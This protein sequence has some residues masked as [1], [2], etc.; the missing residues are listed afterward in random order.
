MLNSIKSTKLKDIFSSAC[1]ENLKSLIV[2]LLDQDP[3]KKIWSR[4]Y[5]KTH[6]F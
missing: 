4:S 6:F 3:E 1:P 2:G 5:K